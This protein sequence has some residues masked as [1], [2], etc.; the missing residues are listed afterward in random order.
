MAQDIFLK[1]DGITGE[2][3]DDKHKDEIEVLN[4]TWEISQES[5]MHSGSGGGA[6]KATVSDLK[7]EHNID[8]S[9]PNLMKYALTGKH[10]DHA[11]LV[12]RKTGGSPLEYLKITMSDVLVT[13]VAPSGSRN[14]SDHSRETVS[15]SFAKVKQEYVVQNAQGG[16]GG[17]VTAGFDI[18]GNKEV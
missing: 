10:I 3:L 16:S 17:A 7:F 9:S 13:R 14:D 5:T 4:W 1:I 11:T 15:L 12:M 6:G 8:R 18:K 2:S